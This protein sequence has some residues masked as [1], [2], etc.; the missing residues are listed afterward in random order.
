[1]NP[2]RK[3]T[4]RRR[5]TSVRI[6]AVMAPMIATLGLLATTPAPATAQEFVGFDRS[7]F[8]KVVLNRNQ[9]AE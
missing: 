5:N 6:A 8:G 7:S 1:M 4:F 3:E 2:S 9:A